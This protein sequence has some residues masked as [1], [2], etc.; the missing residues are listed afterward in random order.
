MFSTMIGL[1]A[2]IL[3]AGPP[4]Y[5]DGGGRDQPESRLT[6]SY[7]AQAGFADAVKLDCDPAGGGHPKP[8]EACAELASAGGDPDRIEPG[9]YACFLI[10][11][12]VT[13]GVEGDWR[14][15]PVEWRHTYG[16]TCE[17]RRALGV[18][19]AF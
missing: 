16:N 13:A 9:H 7:L 1:T 11:Q 3:M 12:P 5:G 10:Y 14:G 15:K 6:L 2:A 4:G 19:F 8:E 17:M 18:L